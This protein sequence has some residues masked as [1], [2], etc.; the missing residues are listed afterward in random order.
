MSEKSWW[1][2]SSS[3]PSAGRSPSRRS[4]RTASPALPPQ[5]LR[6]RNC[7]LPMAIWR[8]A[9]LLQPRAAARDQAGPLA[10]V[11][12][13]CARRPAIS[14]LCAFAW[15]C[16]RSRCCCRR[17]VCRHRPRTRKTSS[18]RRCACPTRPGTHR[19]LLGAR[20]WHRRRGR[21][22]GT[23]STH[24]TSCRLRFRVFATSAGAYALLFLLLLAG[25]NLRLSTAPA[26]GARDRAP[27]AKT[28]FSQ[29]RCAAVLRGRD[30]VRVDGLPHGGASARDEP[31]LVPSPTARPR[32][33]SAW[34]CIPAV[35]W[36]RPRSKS[37]ASW[38]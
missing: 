7:A 21:R 36:H 10:L 19:H 14:V 33:K 15:S 12:A 13:R 2:P 28:V 35:V 9:R 6:R 31:G 38:R 30:V 26:A 16:A 1:L 8:S 11:P 4:C 23:R 37:W 34:S 27:V 5:N 25:Q 3:S 22:P 17:R 32:F 20:R 18:A 24:A 29:P